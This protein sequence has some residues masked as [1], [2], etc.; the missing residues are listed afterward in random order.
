RVTQRGQ[1]LRLGPD[2]PPGQA[3]RHERPGDLQYL[4][5][6]LGG[7]QPDLRAL[8]LQDRVGGHGR[9]VQQMGDLA[10]LHPGL[11]ADQVDA[12]PYPGR[13][14]LRRGGRLGP[15]GRSGLLVDEQHVGEGAADVYPQAIAHAVLPLALQIAELVRWRYW[16]DKPGCVQPGPLVRAEPEQAAPDMV[17]VLAQ[18]GSCGPDR[19][20]S[21]GQLGHDV[22]HRQRPEVRVR[23]ADDRLPRGEVRVGQHVPGPEDPPG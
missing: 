16:L 1:R 12:V 18:R 21:D 17:V 8:A 11:R 3:A 5:E 15:P 4:P 22:L 23:D 2:D 14:V 10:A 7:D 6:A 20:G 19:P 13:L 9:A